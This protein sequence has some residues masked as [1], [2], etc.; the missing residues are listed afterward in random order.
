MSPDEHKPAIESCRWHGL[1]PF[2]S[3]PKLTV[4]LFIQQVFIEC[5]LSTQHS[6]ILSQM[7]AT[8]N[9]AGPN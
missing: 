2:V 5:P 3:S 7:A 9:L 8:G 6:G 4:S 1:P